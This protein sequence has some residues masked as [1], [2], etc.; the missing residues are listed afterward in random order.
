MSRAGDVRGKSVL[1]IG[2]GPIG[3]LVIA[4]CKRAGAAEIVAVDLHDVRCAAKRLG[5]TRT[6][7]AT[8]ADEIAA[9]QADVAIESSGSPGPGQRRPGPPA[10]GGWSWS[11]CCPPAINPCPSRWPSRAKELVGSF[12]FNDEIDAVIAALA[13]ETWWFDP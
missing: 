6:I 13:D 1:V 3:A 7:H 12:R 8:E 2:A 10:V 5:A 9:V 4:V 11:V